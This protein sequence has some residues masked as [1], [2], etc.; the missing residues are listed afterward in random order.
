MY[1]LKIR[2]DPDGDFSHKCKIF[3]LDELEINIYYETRDLA[4]NKLNI[5][6]NELVET[7]STSKTYMTD[8]IIS[9][10]NFKNY[11]NEIIDKFDTFSINLELGNPELEIQLLKITFINT[12]DGGIIVNEEKPL[13][14]LII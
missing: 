11:L 7:I 8:C 10:K 3:I 1:K 5:F 12:D 2:L 9:I 4:I 13:L 14:D 6:Y